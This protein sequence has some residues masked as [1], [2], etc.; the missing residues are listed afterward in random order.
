MQQQ[1]CGR[2]LGGVLQGLC[3]GLLS[4]RRAVQ[5]L[6]RWGCSGCWRRGG[7]RLGRLLARTS[8]L[9]AAAHPTRRGVTWGHA[10]V[11]QA[12]TDVC[13]NEECGYDRRNQ[14]VH[15]VGPWC[16]E[17]V[18]DRHSLRS[19]P[20]TCC[21]RIARQASCACVSNAGNMQSMSKKPPRQLR[22]A[23]TCHN[24]RP[25]NAAAHSCSALQR[26][27]VGTVGYSCLCPAP[28]IRMFLPSMCL[29]SAD[30]WLPTDG[31]IDVVEHQDMLFHDCP[32]PF[33]ATLLAPADRRM[34]LLQQCSAHKMAPAAE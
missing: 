30:K 12:H 2:Y 9:L 15:M 33:A 32:P 17:A 31:G 34:P 8:L 10:A 14:H 19:I 28:L 7:R 1:G 5:S 24:E 18:H 13:T 26:E 4:S 6:W 29:L 27:I 25:F 23:Q 20:A 3:W 16:R 21:Y 11:G 22:R